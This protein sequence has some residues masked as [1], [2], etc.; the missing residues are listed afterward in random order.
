MKDVDFS[1]CPFIKNELCYLTYFDF[2]K[3]A[4]ILKWFYENMDDDA[5]IFY[6]Y[7]VYANI[8]MTEHY[9]NLIWEFLNSG[10]AECY[11]NL[12]E[13]VSKYKVM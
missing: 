5:K 2:C 11:T 7:Y 4:K 12:I 6:K 9:K 3:N 10:D 1:V 13:A 8:H